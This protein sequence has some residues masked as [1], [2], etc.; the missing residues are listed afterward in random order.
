[1]AERWF[2]VEAT[3]HQ[4]SSFNKVA[5]RVR[6]FLDFCSRRGWPAGDVLGE[7]R[8]RRVQ[9]VERL[10]LS[11][12]ELRSLVASAENPRDRARLATATSTGLRASDLR[13]LHMGN[14]DL[15]S[16]LLRV[17][18]Q[19]THHSPGLDPHSSQRPLVCGFAAARKRSG[20]QVH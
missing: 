4:A 12:D 16:G 6:G 11:A 7:V 5:T 19:K 9:R 3:L 14:V 10:Q 1:L 18:I 13:Q 8:P 17:S 2:S 15:P 20:S